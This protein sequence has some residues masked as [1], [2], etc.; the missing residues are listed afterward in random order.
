M[1]CWSELAA[2]ETG[3]AYTGWAPVPAFPEST[4]PVLGSMLGLLDAPLEAAGPPV[5]V[6]VPVPAPVPPPELLPPPAAA[7]ALPFCTVQLSGAVT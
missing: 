3:W 2:T 4:W 6:P 5:P 1:I 7:T